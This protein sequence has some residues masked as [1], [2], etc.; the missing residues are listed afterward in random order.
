[1]YDLPEMLFQRPIEFPTV[2]ARKLLT[3]WSRLMDQRK[4]ERVAF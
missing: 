4:A 3:G 2:V 1:M